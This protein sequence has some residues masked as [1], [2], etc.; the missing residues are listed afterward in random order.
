M[1]KAEVDA[2]LREPHIGRL[3]TV[4]EDG[5]PHMTPIWPVWDGKVISFALGEHRVHIQNLRRDPR[6]TVIIDED[7]RPRAKRYA[8]GAAAV[9]FRGEVEVLDL[10][11]SVEPL[12]QMFIEHAEKFLDGAVGDSDYWETETGE[13]YHVCLFTPKVMTNWDF[14]KFHGRT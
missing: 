4:R 10:E 1:T 2:F 5:Y 14:R 8:A 13:R 7:W 11:A 3:A 9:V 12:R 6:A